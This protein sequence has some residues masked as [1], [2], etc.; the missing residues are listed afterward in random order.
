MHRAGPAVGISSRRSFGGTESTRIQFTS[1]VVQSPAV[2]PDTSQGEISRETRASQTQLSQASGTQTIEDEFGLGDSTGRESQEG[3]FLSGEAEIDPGLSV[4]TS[5]S[6]STVT[7]PGSCGH[8]SAVQEASAFANE[9]V[10]QGNAALVTVSSNLHSSVTLSARQTVNVC[11]SCKK[12]GQVRG[13]I[14]D[15][16]SIPS[17]SWIARMV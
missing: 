16:N 10:G 1:S 15:L 2:P 17:T 8:R 14:I 12:H 4:E 5:C 6:C 13:P 9:A 11:L 7:K 3:R